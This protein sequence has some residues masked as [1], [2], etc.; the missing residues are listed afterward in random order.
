MTGENIADVI[1]ML[2]VNK[3]RG[4]V[5]GHSGCAVWGVGFDRLDTG[6][7]CSNPAQDMDICPRLYVLCCPVQVEA[8]RRADHSSK[9]SCQMSK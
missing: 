9:E 8:L 2:V 7:V 6:I 4:Y 5:A 1:V 3:N